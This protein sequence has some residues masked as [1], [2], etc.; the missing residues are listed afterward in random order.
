[1]LEIL[2]QG[3]LLGL[4]L[5]AM[6]GPLT[7]SLL[8]TSIEKGL[9]AGFAVAVGI[10]L[11]DLLFMTSV[12]YG[13][14]TIEGLIQTNHF[15][16]TVAITGSIVLCVIGIGILKKKNEFAPQAVKL[17]T[18]DWL[19]AVTQ[20]FMINTIN[21][22]TFIFWTTVMGTIVLKN[23]WIGS[24]ALVFFAG[25]MFTIMAADSIKVILSKPIHRWLTPGRWK[26]IKV[27]S[28]ASF[29]LF[30]VVLLVRS[31]V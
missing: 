19:T 4:V 30:G 18:K 20:G 11:S 13:F 29:I 24:E 25:I 1:M 8:H 10:W 2:G 9:P 17:R 27:I 3:I 6:V 7:V 31:L 21:P 5:A 16:E 28:G 22:F 12:F 15:E 14:Q 23:G 26:T